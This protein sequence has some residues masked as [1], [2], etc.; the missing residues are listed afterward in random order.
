MT[1]TEQQN[2]AAAL[3]MQHEGTLT[4]NSQSLPIEALAGERLTVLPTRLE[5]M[6][7]PPVIWPYPTFDWVPASLLLD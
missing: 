6:H 1:P 3:P 5:T 7:E 4:S 2:L